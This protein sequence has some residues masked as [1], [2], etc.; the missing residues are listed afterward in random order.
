MIAGSEE[1]EIK[2]YTSLE[3]LESVFGEFFGSL[4]KERE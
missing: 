4:K 2:R 3:D 1:L